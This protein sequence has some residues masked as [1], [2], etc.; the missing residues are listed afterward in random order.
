M[1]GI[2]RGVVLGKVRQPGGEMTRPAGQFVRLAQGTKV[3]LVDKDFW[4]L[5]KN[6]TKWLDQSPAEVAEDEIKRIACYTARG[7][8]TTY[9]FERPEKGKDLELT[10]GLYSCGSDDSRIIPHKFVA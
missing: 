7:Q 5:P 3:F 4:R 1:R 2:V 8:E 9:V 10:F 6:P